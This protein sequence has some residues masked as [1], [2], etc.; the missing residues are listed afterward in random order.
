[1]VYLTDHMGKRGVACE[2]TVKIQASAR[3]R[4]VSPE[5]LQFT[6]HMTEPVGTCAQRVRAEG[7]Q[8]L[9]IGMMTRQIHYAC[10]FYIT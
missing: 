6:H 10:F 5:S 2:P 1:M 4:V 8:G 7:P 9:L 3:I